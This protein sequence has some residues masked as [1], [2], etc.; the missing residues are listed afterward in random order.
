[1]SG[2]VCIIC[3]GAMKYLGDDINEVYQIIKQEMGDTP[4]ICPFT[5]GEQGRFINGENGHGNLMIS[6]VTFYSS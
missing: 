5:F 2:S 3:A 6:S 4:F 1:M